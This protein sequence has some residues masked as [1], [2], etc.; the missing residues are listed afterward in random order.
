[1]LGLHRPLLKSVAG[2]KIANMHQSHFAT[3]EIVFGYVY[4]GLLATLAVIAGPFFTPH[5][6]QSGLDWFWD[7][8]VLALGLVYLWGSVMF[9]QPPSP[10]PW[11]QR[12]EAFTVLDCG[13]RAVWAGLVTTLAAVLVAVSAPLPLVIWH[14]LIA[15]ILS[16]LLSASLVQ[17]GWRVW[18]ALQSKTAA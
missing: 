12:R 9:H 2:Y 14:V 10:P 18:A 4:A 11:D 8:G 7:R 13:L 16:A 15:S 3:H 6:A 5:L 1:M 17:L